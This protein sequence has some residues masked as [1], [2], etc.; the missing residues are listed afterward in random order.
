MEEMQRILQSVGSPPNVMQ[1]FAD[2]KVFHTQDVNA[3]INQSLLQPENVQMVTSSHFTLNRFHQLPWCASQNI[4]IILI[5]KRKFSLLW[6]TPTPFIKRNVAK[7]LFV[8]Q[9]GKT[10]HMS[11]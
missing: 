5:E 2:E 7:M 6:Q 10:W 8:I 9:S 4:K 3:F 1:S 11:P